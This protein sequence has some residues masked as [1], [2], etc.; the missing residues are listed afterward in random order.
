MPR[1]ELLLVGLAAGCLLITAG[2]SGGSSAATDD[3]P[4]ST[5]G[6]AITTSTVVSVSSSVSSVA[7]TTTTTTTTAPPVCVVAVQSGDSLGAIVARLDGSITMAELVD[8]NRIDETD[9]IHPGQR[10]DV[11]AGNDIDDVTGMS[12]LAPSPAR[13]KRQQREL[14][15]LFAPYVFPQLLVDGDSGP[16]TRQM[17]CAAR[18][19]LGL[20]VSTTH[21]PEGSDEEAA[22]FE[23]TSLA[24]PKG[25]ATWASKWILIDATCQVIF[26]GEGEHGIVQVFPTS[27]GEADFPTHN[28]QAL[29]A[30]RFDP[31]LDNDGWHDS[32][33]FPSE[34]D[35][36]LNGNMYK[37]IYFNGGQAIHGAGYVPP[38]P[39]SKG[40]ARTFPYH[41]DLLIQWLGLDDITEPVWNKDVIAATVTVQGEYRDL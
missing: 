4:A 34:V 20:P 24:I 33:H 8:E 23:A 32:T 22:V 15:E 5:T 31:A 2:C 38:T 6:P 18:M 7:T 39:R 9:V 12:R 40:C 10:F 27:T 1:R 37:P 30:Y 11:C 26:T 14:N 35:N 41:Q 28:A 25:A 21:L 36:P 16:L 17:L 3:A 19:G 13:V 29:S